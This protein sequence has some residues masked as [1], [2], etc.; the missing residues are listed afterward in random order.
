MQTVSQLP[1]LTW[2]G[3]KASFYHSS[4]AMGELPACSQCRP[5]GLLCSQNHRD[6]NG[7]CYTMTCTS[8]P[9]SCIQLVLCHESQTWKLFMMQ[10]SLFAEVP[11]FCYSKRT[12]NIKGHQLSS[13]LSP[14]LLLLFP[15][16]TANSK[17]LPVMIQGRNSGF[18]IKIM[19][20][21]RIL[22]FGSKISTAS[23]YVLYNLS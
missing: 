17:H 6:S 13:T 19:G 2:K 20:F 9:R 5:M 10:Q 23:C 16:H 11:I 22:A 8:L 18:H 1:E 7:T 12:V 3:S 4:C 14:R 21:W 15:F